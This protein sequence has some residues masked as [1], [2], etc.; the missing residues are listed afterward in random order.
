MNIRY[1]T[2]KTTRLSLTI[3]NINRFLRHFPVQL[4]PNQPEFIKSKEQQYR[5][6]FN[7]LIFINHLMLCH[8]TVKLIVFFVLHTPSPVVFKEITIL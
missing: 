4:N 3:T 6:I 7:L 5:Q 8:L 2:T 1:L